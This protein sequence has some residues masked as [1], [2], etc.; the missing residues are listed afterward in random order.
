V[1]DSNPKKKIAILGGG[2]GAISAAF[3]LTNTPELASQH[4]ITIYQL[5][6][7]IGGK[8]ASGRNQARQRRNEEHGLH[9]W[10]GLYENAFWA[11]RMCYEEL[12]RAQQAPLA[13]WEEAFRPKSDFVFYESYQDREVDWP[14]TF[15]TNDSKPGDGALLPTFWD[16]A[17]EFVQWAWEIFKHVLEYRPDVV[18]PPKATEPQFEDRPE[19]W[20][21][22]VDELDAGWSVL[23]KDRYIL[24]TLSLS[25]QL[26]HARRSSPELHT[27]PNHHSYLCSMLSDF[28][29]W[30]WDH[31]MEAHIDDDELR[32]FFIIFDTGTAIVCGI[33]EDDLLTKGMTSV[34]D[35]EFS[36]WL[37]RHGAREEPTVKSGPPV[38]A[39][40]DLVFGYEDGDLAK[41]NFAAGTALNVILRIIFTY[42]GAI[43][44]KMQ[45]GMG[46]TV[47]VP[48]YEVL[49]RRGV[50]FKFFH[51]VTALK[52]DH[53]SMEITGIEIVPQVQLTVDE[54]DPLIPVRELPCFPT[55]PLWYQLENGS[56]LQAQGVN[57]EYAA[58]PLKAAPILLQKGRHF[59]QVI[60]GISI[61]GLPAICGEIIDRNPS[62]Q[63]MIANIKT[64]MT[65]AFQLWVNQD[66]I[67]GLGW[68]HKPGAMGVTYIEPLSTVWSEDQ[69]IQRENWPGEYD[70]KTVAYWCGV[71]QDQ[72]DDTQEKVT[73][74]AKAHALEFLKTRIQHL[75][76]KATQNPESPILNWN[77]LVDPQR[78]T[79]EERFDSQYWRGNFQPSERYVLSV[80]KSTK[81]RLRSDESG[82]HNLFLVGDWIRT[83]FDAG[84]I[85]SATMSGMQASR[86]I[87]GYPEKVIGE[88]D[89]WF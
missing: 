87:C 77:L 52:A 85:E 8:G 31:V 27:D 57:F 73:A 88:K 40:Y 26:T 67:T 50:K 47:F 82:Y 10:F 39:A 30:L 78:C 44:W 58:N 4:D 51:A 37:I 43:F 46:D 15:P 83:G 55:E 68:K 69:L 71:I 14:L 45:A 48:F 3:C 6:W 54:Y 49:K 18:S 22:L 65:Q 61:A 80:A 79:G 13:T 38:Q 41:P 76:P 66:L 64:V 70:L 16:M 20:D 60:L 32:E 72:P 36:D 7:R 11:M 29:T 19:W 59:D 62:W 56:E 74:R 42:K 12:A 86:A 23:E 34:D 81:F 35:E 63:Q 33:V 25:R 21:R 28:K 17:D 2:M 89:P 9:M 53:D 75:W 24:K 84:C 1:T 5:G